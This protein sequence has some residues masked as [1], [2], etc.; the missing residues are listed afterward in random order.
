MHVDLVLTPALLLALLEVDGAG[1]ELACILL[2]QALFKLLLSPVAIH[3]NSEEG[4]VVLLALG[5][6]LDPL[7]IGRLVP[8]DL[9]LQP[10][11]ELAS[12]MAGA[13]FAVRI[14]WVTRLLR[15][16]V[17]WLLTWIRSNGQGCNARS[18]VAI[19]EIWA[20]AVFWD[21]RRV[22]DLEAVECSPRLGHLLVRTIHGNSALAV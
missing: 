19:C 1:G 5:P 22:W 18:T 16:W 21:A 7:S 8:D 9:A 6:K 10:A 15:N 11:S 12:A 3:V 17:G 14:H 4:M 20:Q 13:N 2:A